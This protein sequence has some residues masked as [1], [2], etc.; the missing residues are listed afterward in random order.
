ID[1]L[2][3]ECRVIYKNVETL[4]AKINL[5]K[6]ELYLPVKVNNKQDTDELEIKGELQSAP[7]AETEA[8]KERL[9]EYERKCVKAMLYVFFLEENLYKLHTALANIKMYNGLLHGKATIGI[10]GNIVHDK[11]WGDDPDRTGPLL[12]LFS[13]SGFDDRIRSDGKTLWGGAS[14]ASGGVAG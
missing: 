2:R 9:K 6:K 7:I 8:D 5:L 1:L 10:M 13:D 4:Q 14:H 11:T 12:T 3:N